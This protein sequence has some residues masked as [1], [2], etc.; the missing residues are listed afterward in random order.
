MKEVHT[1]HATQRPHTRSR[2]RTSVALGIGLLTVGAVA[3][4]SVAGAVF[5]V[6]LV[7]AGLGLLTSRL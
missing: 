7:V 4:V 2:S 6:P 5:G 1:M 3:T